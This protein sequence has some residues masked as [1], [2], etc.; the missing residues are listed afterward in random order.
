[1]SEISGNLDI[2]ANEVVPTLA[3][4]TD[5]DTLSTS[6]VGQISSSASSLVSVIEDISAALSA[7]LL[8]DILSTCSEISSYAESI[9][10]YAD[11]ISA[12]AE[13][14]SAYADDISSNSEK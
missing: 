6:I 10:A 3:T 14:I 7:G 5:L 11:S 1:M 12:Y 4:K 13:S 2:L 9:S 8:S